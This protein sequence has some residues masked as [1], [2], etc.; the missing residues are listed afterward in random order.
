MSFFLNLNYHINFYFFLLNNRNATNRA[1][2]HARASHAI[3]MMNLMGILLDLC[4][5][6]ACEQTQ[7]HKISVVLWSFVVLF[8]V[9]FHFG[10]EIHIA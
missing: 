1:K 2:S 6:G 4:M 10:G 9:L 5:H 3:T 7:S 8:G